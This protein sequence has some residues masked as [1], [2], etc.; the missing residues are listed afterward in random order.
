MILANLKHFSDTIIKNLA[1]CITFEFLT[2]KTS[3]LSTNTIGQLFI[4]RREQSGSFLYRIE[5]GK[6]CVNFAITKLP[7]TDLGF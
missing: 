5:S 6:A 7:V 4:Y 3:Y 2:L 1:Q